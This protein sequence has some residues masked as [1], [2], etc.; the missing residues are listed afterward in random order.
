MSFDVGYSI[1]QSDSRGAS[2]QELQ[3]PGVTS[4]YSARD[5][6]WAGSLRWRF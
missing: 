4:Q 3:H 1:H 6:V 5:Q 2:G